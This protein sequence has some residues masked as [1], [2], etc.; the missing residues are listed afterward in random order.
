MDLYD[1]ARA[2]WGGEKIKESVRRRGKRQREKAVSL[3]TPL[4]QCHGDVASKPSQGIICRTIKWNA[5]IKDPPDPTHTHRK[6]KQQQQAQAKL[7]RKGENGEKKTRGKGEMDGL[8]RER[9]DKGAHIERLIEI[10]F[11]CPAGYCLAVWLTKAISS[12][13]QVGMKI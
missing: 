1:S 12:K 11:L 5:L 7:E 13:Q 9:S 6:I 8:D 10:P 4:A 3:Q 2:E